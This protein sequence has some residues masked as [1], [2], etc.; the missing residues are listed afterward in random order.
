MR[1]LKKEIKAAEAAG[2]EFEAGRR[3]PRLV[4]PTGVMGPDGEPLPP[5]YLAKTPSDVRSDKNFVAQLRRSGV[6]V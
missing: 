5:I 2:W 1:R 3:H 6:D 4:P